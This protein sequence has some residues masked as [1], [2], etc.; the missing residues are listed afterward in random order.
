MGLLDSKI[1]TLVSI[2]LVIII[3]EASLI[4]ILDGTTLI[5]LRLYGIINIAGFIGVI[6]AGVWLAER[7]RERRRLKKNGQLENR[8]AKK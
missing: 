6:V 5:D 2:I 4:F 7:G 1:G 8:E 3:Y